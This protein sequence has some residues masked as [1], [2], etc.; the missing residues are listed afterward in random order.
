MFLY[1]WVCLLSLLFVGFDCGLHVVLGVW[2]VGLIYV[3]CLVLVG[4]LFCF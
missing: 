2:V 1:F 4:L 3:S